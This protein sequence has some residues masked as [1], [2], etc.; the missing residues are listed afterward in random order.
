MNGA[1][2]LQAARGP[3]LLITLGVLFLLH[4]NTEHNFNRTF[5][6]LLIVF[7][8]MKL[9]EF[10]ASKNMEPASGP[11]YGVGGPIVTP[12]YTPPQPQT[13]TPPSSPAARGV[14][15][16]PAAAAPPPMTQQPA[17]S[18]TNETENP[19]TDGS[20]EGGIR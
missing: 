8:L 10:F 17:G 12:P 14:Y 11:A 19:K 20:E 6:V 4:Q 18:A 1:T 16:A 15:T 9:M 2:L 13:Y 3:V 7:G 5:P